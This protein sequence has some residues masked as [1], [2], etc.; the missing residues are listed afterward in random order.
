MSDKLKD[1]VYEKPRT[2]RKGII[3]LIKEHD[4]SFTFTVDEKLFQQFK[5]A[6]VEG[7]K[8]QKI[9]LSFEMR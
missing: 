9:D 2:V 4:G 3:M 7:F 1:T 5:E 8:R 6:L